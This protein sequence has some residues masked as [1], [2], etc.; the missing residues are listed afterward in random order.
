[1]LTDRL[2]LRLETSGFGFEGGLLTSSRRNGTTARKTSTFAVRIRIRL[3]SLNIFKGSIL[4][5]VA[6]LRYCNTFAIN[7]ISKT[8]ALTLF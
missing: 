8:V 7:S 3:N 1:M 4:A 5:I 6:R 2:E